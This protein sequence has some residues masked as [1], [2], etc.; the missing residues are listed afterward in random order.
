MVSRHWACTG[1]HWIRTGSETAQRAAAWLVWDQLL[2]AKRSSGMGI[3]LSSV[4]S[5]I[6]QE[7]VGGVKHSISKVMVARFLQVLASSD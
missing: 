5:N 7:W 3:L 2:G 4:L 6:K 1:V